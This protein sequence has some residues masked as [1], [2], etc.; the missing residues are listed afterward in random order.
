M[1]A[2]VRESH[3]SSRPSAGAAATAVPENL[4]L[5]AEGFFEGAGPAL[6]TVLSRRVTVKLTAVT[7]STGAA[8]RSEPLPW[9]VAEVTYQRGL[10]GTHWLVLPSKSALAL[11]RALVGDPEEPDIRAEAMQEALNQVLAAAGPTLMPLLGRGVSYAPSTARLIETADAMPDALAS[12]TFW[13]A[14]ARTSAD[15]DV[16]SDV[17]LTIPDDVAREIAR[18]GAPRV[19]APAAPEARA[20][21]PPTRLDMILDVTLPVTVELGRARMQIHEILKL[22][23]GSVIE[24]DKSAGDPV[25]LFINDRP[26]AKGEVVV[27]DENFGVR[28]T[29]IVTAS[30]RIK[31]LR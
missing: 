23:P 2:T 18:A 12:G 7:A 29:S 16:E 3:E 30:E 1:Q 27:I 20:A 8:L 26:I 9:V 13:L 4:D 14:R 25:E 28:L 19:E 31:T 17:W 11:T 6:S 10:R 5:F 21:E 15:G 22:A 24:L